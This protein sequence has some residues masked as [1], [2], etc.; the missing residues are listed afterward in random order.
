MSGSQHVVYTIKSH[1]AGHSTRCSVLNS[2]AKQQVHVRAS[3]F[4]T[5]YVARNQ[6][7]QDNTQAYAGMRLRHCTHPEVHDVSAQEIGSSLLSSSL[8]VSSIMSSSS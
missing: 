2:T 7:A 6:M 8:S 5:F 1:H 3:P 4:P